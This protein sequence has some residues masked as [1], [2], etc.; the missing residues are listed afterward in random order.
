MAGVSKI[1]DLSGWLLPDGDWYE[2]SEWWHVAA[3]YDLQGG[4]FA[5]L[6]SEETS[7]ILKRGEEAE[8]RNHVSLL[9]LIKISRSFIDG[10]QMNLAQLKTLQ[11]LL[12][13]CDLEAEFRYLSG[14]DGELRAVSVARILKLKNASLFFKT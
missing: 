1:Q 13:V 5:L 4:G 11:V 10:T 12:E 6:Q 14:S 9:G 2:T 8:I 7:A 3:L